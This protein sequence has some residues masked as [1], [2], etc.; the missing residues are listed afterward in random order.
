[1]QA[2]EVSLDPTVKKSRRDMKKTPSVMEPQVHKPEVELI[3]HGSVTLE[4]QTS[5]RIKKKRDGMKR[6]KTKELTVA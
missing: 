5:K 1:M 2:S 6:S 4:P 3:R